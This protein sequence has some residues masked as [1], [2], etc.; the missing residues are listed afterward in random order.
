MQTIH[1]GVLIATT[2]KELGYVLF[3]SD[4]VSRDF[5]GEKPYYMK[6]QPYLQPG[7]IFIPFVLVFAHRPSVRVY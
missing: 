1:A 6:S 7:S 5:I 2:I 3:I 4:V